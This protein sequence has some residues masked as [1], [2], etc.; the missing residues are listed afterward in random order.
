M[1]KLQSRLPFKSGMWKITNFKWCRMI[2]W[3][4]PIRFLVLTWWLQSPWTCLSRWTTLKT[5]SETTRALSSSK[6][7]STF[8]HQS[9]SSYPMTQQQTNCILTKSARVFLV[10]QNWS[11]WAWSDFQTSC[12]WMIWTSLRVCYSSATTNRW[13][14]R[15]LLK[16]GSLCSIP[17]LFQK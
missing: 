7:W 3:W 4:S 14:L 1:P 11:N 15:A 10:S 6:T 16:K 2:S 8:Y 17:Y 9:T 12:T 13:W 5:Y